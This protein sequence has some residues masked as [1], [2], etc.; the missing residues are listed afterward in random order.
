MTENTS[1][2]RQRLLGGGLNRMRRKAPLL[3]G[4]GRTGLRRA[5]AA[6]AAFTFSLVVL[7]LIAASVL[8]VLLGNGTLHFDLGAQIASALNSRIGGGYVFSVG[9][10]AFR[11]TADGPGLALTE[12][13]VR[14]GRGQSVL[15]SPH[16]VVSVDLWALAL[17]RVV[18]RRL[19]LADLE[20]HVERLP[21][22][23]L[24][25]SAGA[26][27]TRTDVRLNDLLGTLGVP[28]DAAGTAASSSP[29]SGVAPSTGTSQLSAASPN[30]AEALARAVTGLTDALFEDGSPARAVERLGLQN[31]TLVVDD[32]LRNT[33]LTY[34][35]LTLDLDREATGGLFLTIAADGPAGHWSGAARAA[36]L[37]DGSRRVEL[38]V[39]R[40]SSDEL[41][42][43]AGQRAAGFETDMPL[44]FSLTALVGPDGRLREAGGPVSFGAGYFR[45]DDPDHEPAMVDRFEGVL[46]LDAVTGAVTLGKGVLTA[47]DTRFDYELAAI[48]PTAAD[49]PWAVTGHASG[50]FGKE[51]PGEGP[52]RLDRIDFKAAVFPAARKIEFERASVGGPEVNF[53]MKATLEPTATG[54][55]VT[56]DMQMGR[57]PGAVVLRLW[58]NWMAAPVRAWLLRNLRGGF[59][60][61]GVG[62][63]ALTDGDLDRMRQQHSVP[64]DHVHIAFDV[65][66]AALQFMDGVPPLRGIDGSGKLTGDSFTFTAGKAEMEVAP[67]HRLTASEGRFEVPSTDPKPTPAT[68]SLK[69]AGAIDALADLLN[70]DALKP[71]A[72]LPIDAATVSGAFDGRLTI[73]LVMGGHDPKTDTQITVAATARDFT[74]AKVIGKEPLQNAT[75]AVTADPT[76]LKAKGEGRMYGAPTQVEIRKPA[77]GGPSEAIIALTLDDAARQKAG[78]TLGRSL[79]GT[80]L[81]RITT[82]L[83]PS[84]KNKASVLLDFTRCAFDNPLPGLR[85]PVDRPAKAVLTVLQEPNR[86]LLEGIDFDMGSAD[87]RGSA[88]LDGNGAFVSAALS[89]VRVSPGDDV[90]ADIQR[91]G[92]GYKAVVRAGTFDARP[93]LK[94]AAGADAPNTGEGRDIDLDMHAN[95]VTGQN[96]QTMTGVDLRL[97]KKGGQ[98]RRLQLAGK[99]G[100]G[101]VSATT[102]AQGNVPVVAVKAADAGAALSFLDLYKRM[103]GGALDSTLRFADS[104]I[105]GSVVIRTFLIK[106]DPSIRKLAAEQ[107]PGDSRN[108]GAR[109][110][111]SAVAFTKLEAQFTR[112]GNRV[113]VRQGAMFGPQLGA[114]VEGSLDFAKDKVALSGTFVPI[115]GLNNL[116]SQIPV[117]GALLGGGA[118]EGLFALNYRITGSAS[119][120]VLTF[121]PL[122]AL[123]PG[124]LR[125]I[126]GALDDA[127]QQGMQDAETRDPGGAP[128][129]FPTTRSTTR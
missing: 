8:I 39:D 52:I 26:G 125:K 64:A 107:I 58:P 115:Y 25:M 80:M 2:I 99:L 88:V 33:T 98:V 122:S 27:Q 57:M 44:S 95:L 59:I 83:T 9:G 78:L 90:K 108:A 34:R 116:F 118:H 81:A 38:A 96:A 66:G 85:K 47:D 36:R 41:L 63:V 43:A 102:L 1:F 54:F 128:S 61:S 28:H 103:D 15:V 117:V 111:P 77:G 129:A 45:I 87:I 46:A 3:A 19:E 104:R 109:I 62:H 124:F 127:A 92:D 21:D 6:I 79:T 67:G 24:A 10:T 56:S 70:R 30:L 7:G 20:L 32:R 121:N 84:E 31:A 114:T 106:E 14:D 100:G 120:P 72:N 71:F 11:E 126:F 74:A 110:D 82:S 112:S 75:L 91:S 5:L 119:A 65:T 48:P 105:D 113:D 40:L 49:K 29:P 23:K 76:G 73:G 69:V 101:A 17:G 12:L 55:L 22:G 68:V 42:L 89:Q 94:L 37:P 60:E 123:A 4:G 93:Y 13:T 50:V 35:N 18:P 16:A 51:R 97:V 53:T 86:T